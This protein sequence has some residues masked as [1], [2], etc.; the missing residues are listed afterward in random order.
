MVSERLTS[1]MDRER[2]VQS[3]SGMKYY[4]KSDFHHGFYQVPLARDLQAY[5]VTIFDRQ[6]YAFVRLPIG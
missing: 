5:V 4:T 2:A 6:P 3:L 1:K